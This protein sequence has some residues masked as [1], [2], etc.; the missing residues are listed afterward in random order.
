[1]AKHINHIIVHNEEEKLT[2]A[3]IK[4]QKSSADVLRQLCGH[5]MI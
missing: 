4:T 2:T 3:E 1:M 5:D